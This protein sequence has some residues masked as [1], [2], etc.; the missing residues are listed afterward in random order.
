MNRRVEELPCQYTQVFVYLGHGGG[1]QYL[2]RRAL[3]RNLFS[4]ESDDEIFF[5]PISPLLDPRQPHYLA[6]GAAAALAPSRGDPCSSVPCDSRQSA[7]PTA[8]GTDS[9]VLTCRTSH[10][11]SL[12]A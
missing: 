11:M 5:R 4:H 8:G 6:H 3:V 9:C 12:E 7:P 2:P 1:E 10:H